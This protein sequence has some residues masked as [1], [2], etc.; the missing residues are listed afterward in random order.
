MYGREL[1]A[2]IE[3]IPFL[4][5]NFDGVYNYEDFPEEI[6][7]RHFVILNKNIK[8]REVGH[9]ILL[10]RNED[11]IEVFDSLGGKE[12]DILPIKKLSTTFLINGTQ[13]QGPASMKCG[14]FCLYA[15]F[16]RLSCLD[17]TYESVLNN[18]FSKNYQVNE[19]KIDFFFNKYC[20]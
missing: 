17:Q 2:C 10:L 7:D 16:W 18:I 5:E 9:W 3:K 4:G 6:K 19:E 1:K 8:N 11:T 15:A 14:V 12:S 20:Q 13:V